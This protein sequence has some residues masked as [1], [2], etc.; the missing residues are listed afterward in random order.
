MSMSVSVGVSMEALY[1]TRIDTSVAR[2]FESS[3]LR[4]YAYEI[5]VLTATSEEADVSCHGTGMR[6]RGE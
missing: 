5:G 1:C 3:R 2:K 4:F 6:S